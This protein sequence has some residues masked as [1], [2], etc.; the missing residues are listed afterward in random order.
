[1]KNYLLTPFG[2]ILLFVLLL[3]NQ[4]EAKKPKFEI[5]PDLNI[6][7]EKMIKR[8]LVQTNAKILS[9]KANV[10]RGK[11]CVWTGPIVLYFGIEMFKFFNEPEN[12]IP[13]FTYYAYAISGIMISSGVLMVPIG[14][15]FAKK[16]K[17]KL[18]DAK[19]YKQDIQLIIQK[20]S[21]TSLNEKP[22]VGLGLS[23]A[24]NFQ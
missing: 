14:I 4:L 6:M 13:P 11:A 10:F 2:L 9:Y 20:Y 12:F 8:E 1:M 23:V 21:A 17:E 15:S 3:P 18:E 22:G 24:L 7:N 5:K 19:S 16:N